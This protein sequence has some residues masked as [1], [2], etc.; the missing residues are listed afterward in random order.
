MALFVLAKGVRMNQA[1]PATRNTPEG[2]GTTEPMGWSRAGSFSKLPSNLPSSKPTVRDSSR[3]FPP[4]GQQGEAWATQPHF[5]WPLLHP[6]RLSTGAQLV[7]VRAPLPAL[8]RHSRW[9]RLFSRGI[10]RGQQTNHANWI[11]EESSAAL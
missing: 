11:D 9:F 10:G 7:P 2:P 3:A 5:P 6:T 1:S 4:Q 8:R